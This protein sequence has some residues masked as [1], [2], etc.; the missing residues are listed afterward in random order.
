MTSKDDPAKKDTIKVTVRKPHIPVGGVTVDK[1]DIDLVVGETDKITVTVTPENAT[2]KS[3]TYTSSDDT[4]AIV[5]ENG[6]ITAVGEGEA[7]IT[8][9]SKDDPAKKYT[10]SVTVIVETPDEP[11]TPDVPEEPEYF[12]SAPDKVELTEYETINLD[13]RVYP[14][15]GAPAITY[16]SADESVATVDAEGNVRG[17]GAGETTIRAEIPGGEFAVVTV[18]V[19]EAVGGY[20]TS[21]YIVFGKTEKIGWYS[22][23][24]DGGKTFMTV[25]GNSNME[26]AEGTVLIIR[27]NDVL[28]DPF[29]FFIN[30][31]A[32][33]PDE[34]GYVTVVVDGYMLIGALGTPVEA[35]DTEESLNLF[36][37]IIKAIKEFFAK[38]FGR[39]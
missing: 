39:D 15:H 20:E 16:T 11:D 33:Y 22:V 14:A 6:K 32:T 35:P 23:S 13:I 34:N 26:V 18:V 36:Q 9:T 2:D 12:L 7:V 1:S 19:Y 10:I 27:A 25:Y 28:G 29:K 4:V 5:D 38:L 24:T 3:V 17:I 30:G 31:N 37:R 8:V 21:H